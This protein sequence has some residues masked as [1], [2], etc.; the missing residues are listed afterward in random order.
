MRHALAIAAPPWPEGAM[1]RASLILAVPLFALAAPAQAQLCDNSN[2]RM[3]ADGRAFGHLPYGDAPPGELVAVPEGLAVGSCVLRRDVVPDLARLIAASGGQ[4]R[5]LSCHRSISYQQAVFCRE[6]QTAAG[7][8]ALS[9][10]P[11]GHSEHATGYALDFAFR[12]RVNDCPDAEACGAATPAFRWLVANAA[13]Y[14]FEMSFP[15]GNRQRVK[16]EPWHWRWVGASATAPGAA[17]ARA[18]FARA[19]AAFPAEPPVERDPVVIASVAAPP[20]YVGAYA[21][22]ECRKG[23]CRLPKARRP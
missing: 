23:K 12:P 4:V 9:V 22:P 17:R 16:W 10:A 20:V 13:R 19:R 7:E 5:A 1:R 8:R 11:P 14:G 15:A 2:V 18:L 3:G 21:P 6:A